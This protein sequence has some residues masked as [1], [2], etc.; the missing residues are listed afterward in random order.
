LTG[1]S[2][3][4]EKQQAAQGAFVTKTPDNNASLSDQDLLNIMLSKSPHSTVDLSNRL[5]HRFGDL[6]QLLSADSQELSAIAGVTE[7]RLQVLLALPE[8]ARRFFVQSLPPG[9]TIRSPADTE[10][11]LHAKLRDLPHELFCCLFLDNRH[12]VLSFEEADSAY[13]G[14]YVSDAIRR[15]GIKPGR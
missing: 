13:K 7:K 10:A 4:D 11:F 14:P 3:L 6:R 5:L 12:R 9:H 8:L 15:T 2:C 1:R